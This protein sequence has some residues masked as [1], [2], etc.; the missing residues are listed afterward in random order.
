[1]KNKTL[2][3]AFILLLFSLVFS[4]HGEHS[5]RNR[6]YAKNS[7]IQPQNIPEKKPKYD[8]MS[9]FLSRNTK[10][11]GLKEDL[12]LKRLLNQPNIKWAIRAGKK[13]I[14]N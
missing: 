12:A 6:S 1:M 14:L 5:A 8:Y 10:P 2:I 7:A 11:L 13:H 4:S 3:I 9:R